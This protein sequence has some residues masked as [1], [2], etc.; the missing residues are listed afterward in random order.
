[1]VQTKL[2]KFKTKIARSLVPEYFRD[3]DDKVNQRVANVMLS[4]DPFEALMK[5][6]HGVFSKEYQRAEEQLDDR[7]Q[8]QMMMWGSQ[9]CRDPSFKYMTEWVMNMQANETLKRAPVTEERILYGRAQVSCM[10]LFVKE[11]E[12]LGLLYDDYL[13]KQKNPDFNSELSTE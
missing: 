8:L 5:R 11:V 4:V 3:F 7:S 9:Q 2:Q 13:Q 6:F 1:M 12:R 10:L